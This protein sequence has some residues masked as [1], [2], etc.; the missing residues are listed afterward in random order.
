MP[1]DPAVEPSSVAE[2]SRT[3][4]ADDPSTWCEPASSAFARI[5]ATVSIMQDN[6]AMQRA[7]RDFAWAPVGRARGAAHAATTQFST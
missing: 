4:T 1:I 6:A 2:P 3:Y 7:N 5:V